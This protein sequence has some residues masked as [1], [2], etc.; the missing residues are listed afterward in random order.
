MP[1]FSRAQIN[2]ITQTVKG[3]VPV[4]FLGDA[5]SMECKPFY[6]FAYQTYEFIRFNK[7]WRNTYIGGE[8]RAV[9][10]YSAPHSRGY[11]I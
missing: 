9:R 11:D 8:S 1:V 7:A 4:T 10:F 5:I 2:Q 3:T 6:I